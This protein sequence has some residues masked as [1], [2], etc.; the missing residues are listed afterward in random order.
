MSA[1]PPTPPKEEEAPEFTATLIAGYKQLAKAN[2][3]EP[4][5]SLSRDA[6]T[7]LLL[8]HAQEA[9][10]V[11]AS[12]GTHEASPLQKLLNEKGVFRRNTFRKLAPNLLTCIP[13]D[14]QCFCRHQY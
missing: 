8:D 4:V 12:S 5:L 7:A 2:L 14:G 6:L 3:L 10:R 11:A 13:E 1:T 9:A